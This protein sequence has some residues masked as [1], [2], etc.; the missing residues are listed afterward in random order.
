M[1]WKVGDVVDVKYGRPDS[2]ATE[3][4]TERFLLLEFISKTYEMGDWH[5][6]FRVLVIRIT[7]SDGKVRLINRKDTKW[8]ASART[9]L[10]CRPEE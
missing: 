5:W 3:R 10:V 2:F 1:S 8:F 9:T 4:F 7:T 6:F